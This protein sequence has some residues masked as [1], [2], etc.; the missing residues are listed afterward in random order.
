M[1]D[2]ERWIVYPI[3][4]YSVLLGLKNQ[5]MMGAVT[6]DS[7]D[8]R[9]L[10]VTDQD[11]T[12]IL[13][14]GRADG[15]QILVFGDESQIFSVRSTDQG[16]NGQATVRGE[17]GSHVTLHA[18]PIGSTAK[19]ETNN[20]K[21][22]IVVGHSLTSAVD[23]VAAIQYGRPCEA[24]YGETGVH[25]FEPKVT[26]VQAEVE[27]QP[28]IEG[29]SDDSQTDAKEAA[30]RKREGDADGDPSVPAEV[31]PEASEQSAPARDVSAAKPKSTGE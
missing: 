13:L 6:F 30:P 24:E 8:V 29:S 7:I 14:S 15:G 28:E 20:L 3:L 25:F 18:S 17:K 9:R 23:G 5:G 1:S 21:P 26:T 27:G 16:K 2:R 4:F 10:T 19:V 11:K 22:Q 31:T 12:K